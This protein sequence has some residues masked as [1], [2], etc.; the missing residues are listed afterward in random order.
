MLT[1]TREKSIPVVTPTCQRETR[2]ELGGTR[3]REVGAISTHVKLDMVTEDQPM[4]SRSQEL[5]V[6][7][8]TV[9]VPCFRSEAQGVSRLSA[10][11]AVWL[12]QRGPSND[13]KHSRVQNHLV[14]LQWPLQIE[15]KGESIAS[16][17]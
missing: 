15:V 2:L 7:R 12:L 10:A 5:R 16:I 3:R 9:E 14:L 17:I 4:R 8:R 13:S 1:T 6:R 11:S